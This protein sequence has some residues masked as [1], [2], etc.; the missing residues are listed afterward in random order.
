MLAA[1]RGGGASGGLGGSGRCAR[2]TVR[3]PRAEDDERDNAPMVGGS[4]RGRSPCPDPSGTARVR[5]LRVRWRLPDRRIGPAPGRP[6]PRRS[7]PAHPDQRH[8]RL[9]RAWCESAARRGLLGRPRL[10]RPAVRLPAGRRDLRPEHPLPRPRLQHHRA[11]PALAP[12]ALHLVRGGQVELRRQRRR[13]SE[14]RSRL[15]LPRRGRVAAGA[16]GHRLCGRAD[17]GALRGSRHERV[18]RRRRARGDQDDHRA[19]QRVRQRGLPVQRPRRRPRGRSVRL[20]RG[21][22]VRHHPAR[23]RRRGGHRQ[24]QLAYGG[25]SAL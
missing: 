12:G 9:R 23:L 21:A 18:G 16:L 19:A 1:R 10:P 24:H 14:L 25:G 22:R 2:L 15:S 3:G 20:G 7:H 13:R 5:A 11:A 6:A 17:G 4:P 8:G